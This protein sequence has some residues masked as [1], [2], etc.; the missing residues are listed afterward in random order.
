MIYLYYSKISVIIFFL[1][2]GGLFKGVLFSNFV[3]YPGG[4][5]EGGGS[6]QGGVIFKYL[7]YT[8]PNQSFSN[9]KFNLVFHSPPNFTLTILYERC[10]RPVNTQRKP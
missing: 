1:R 3:L 4:L 8:I 5:F 2:A 10:K 7:E 6:I 9:F